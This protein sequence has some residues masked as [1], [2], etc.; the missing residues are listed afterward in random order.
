[1]RFD[2]LCG[3]AA[4]QLRRQL[5]LK[6]GTPLAAFLMEH[7]ISYEHTFQR[8][9]D[10]NELHWE[11]MA[12][13]V[14]VAEVA[15]DQETGMVSLHR[16]HALVDVGVVHDQQQAEGQIIGGLMQGIGDALLP[17]AVTS[18]YTEHVSSYWQALPRI[19]ILSAIS[20]EFLA[21]DPGQRAVGIGELGVIPVYQ[22][23]LRAVKKR[24]ESL[25]G[26]PLQRPVIFPL[27]PERVYHLL[28]AP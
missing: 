28:K 5:A 14:L 21:S 16:M 8:S 22:V 9:H 11:R 26:H 18:C 23:I 2:E 24:Y 27:T 3:D 4:S 20:V 13:I 6:E 19:S 15:I 25:Y 10:P 12:Y 7:A 17:V 1:M